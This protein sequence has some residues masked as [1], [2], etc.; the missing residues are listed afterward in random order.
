VRSSF[1][2]ASYCHQAKGKSEY[3]E[4]KLEEDEMLKLIICALITLTILGFAQT[5]ADVV[6]QSKIAEPHVLDLRNTDPGVF[7]SSAFSNQNT[8]AGI[9]NSS[10][11]II[12]QNEVGVPLSDLSFLNASA[13]NTSGRVTP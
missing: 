13:G 2:S 6:R 11:S 8:N 7:N 3:L 4:F 10:A 12:P 5:P 1:L 9:M